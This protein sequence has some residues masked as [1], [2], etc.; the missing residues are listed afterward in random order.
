[1]LAIVDLVVARV[2][3]RAGVAAELL[4]AVMVYYCLELKEPAGGV[5]S[6][7]GHH[8]VPEVVRQLSEA[9]VVPAVRRYSLVGL[10]SASRLIV[11]VVVGSVVVRG[12]PE[13]VEDGVG[14]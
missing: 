10:L 8:G 9:F 13:V 1:M 14:Y 6:H 12:V 3:M 4:V 7:F 5:E 2:V 11:A